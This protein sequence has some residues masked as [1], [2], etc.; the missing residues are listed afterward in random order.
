MAP[1][2]TRSLGRLVLLAWLLPPAIVLADSVR[3]PAADTPRPTTHFLWYRNYDN[4]AV[5]AALSLAFDKTPEYGPYKIERSPEMVQGRAMLELEKEG[6]QLV[7][8]ANVATSPERRTI[9]TPYRYRSM[10]DSWGCVFA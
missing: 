5:L 9:S 1:L 10:E 8:I 3:E 6:N 7:T 4:P 2:I